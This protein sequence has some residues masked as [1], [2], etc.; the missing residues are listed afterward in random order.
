MVAE[1]RHSS[2]HWSDATARSLPNHHNGAHTAGMTT[3]TR[4]QVGRSFNV[5]ATVMVAG[6]TACALAQN[7]VSAFPN[8]TVQII[9]PNAPGAGNDLIARLI[10]PKLAETIKQ[11]V[12]VEN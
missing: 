10:A 2:L 7:G 9:V 1:G 5:V 6:W 3:M 12:V 11:S 4:M 8:K